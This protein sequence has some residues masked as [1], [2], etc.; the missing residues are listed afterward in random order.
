MGRAL[1]LTRR[2]LRVA[3][4]NPPGDERAAAHLVGSILQDAGFVV[5]YDEFAA[6]RTSVVARSA[7]GH[8]D[9]TLCLTGHLDTV[10]LGHAPWSV[11]PFAGDAAG[12][13]LFGRGASDM[14]GGIAAMVCAALDLAGDLHRE[15]GA[16]LV[17]AFTA[18]EETGCQGAFHLCRTGGPWRALDAIVVGE[19]TANQP[20]LGHKGALWLNLMARGR[21][22][23]GAMP[24]TGVNA[25]RRGMQ[26]IGKLDT[27]DFG[28]GPHGALGAPTVNVGTIRGGVNVNSIPDLVHIG[29][30]IR[31]VPG[32]AHGALRERLEGHLAPELAGIEVMLDLEPVWTPATHPWVQEVSAICGVHAGT[33]PATGGASYFTDACAFRG[34]C[35]ADV[36]VVVLGPG[37]PEQ[38]HQTDEFCRISRL[39][40]AVA[41]YRDIIRAW[42]SAPHRRARR[43]QSA[44]QLNSFQLA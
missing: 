28:I 19:P 37:E 5:E 24:G 2:L 35:D 4:V 6:Q 14:K 18:S 15:R 44:T 3:T 40:Q 10:P 13:A 20:L 21:T 38:A 25:I 17:L 7:N 23:H 43:L 26:L 41:I 34:A 12:D 36:P 27:F 9:A 1:D 22:G 31:T 32:L 8:A 33:G 16:A 39:E 30:D 29:I 42:C 11:D